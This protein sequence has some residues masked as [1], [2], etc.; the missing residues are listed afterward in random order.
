[1]T[2]PVGQLL[3]AIVVLGAR[4]AS[5]Q[6]TPAPDYTPPDDTPSVRVGGTLFADYSYTLA[7]EAIDAEGRALQRQLLQRRTGV[8]QRHRPA[9]SPVRLPHHARRRAR[10]G[11]RQLAQRSHDAGLEVRLRAAQPRRLAV[12]R[13]LRARGDDSDAVRGLRGE[14]LSIPLSGHRLRRTRRISPLVRLR[15]RIPN[16]VSQGLRR[17]GRR[18]VQRRRVLAIRDQRSEG[19]AGS[20]HASS[21]SRTPMPHGDCA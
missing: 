13:Q 3:L 14:H 20:R 15:D 4:P 11:R 9:Q 21:V 2:R 12:A 17:G 18:P 7:P 8:S 1:M 19:A 16:A 6:V 5:A 10:D